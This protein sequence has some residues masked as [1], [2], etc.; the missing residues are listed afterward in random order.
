[1]DGFA[2]I[3][4]PRRRKHYSSIRQNDH[5]SSSVSIFIS[6]V[7]SCITVKNIF[8]RW[9]SINY[10]LFFRLIGPV[11]IGVLIRYQWQKGAT[12]LQKITTPFTVFVLLFNLT[13]NV[14]KLL[15][16]RKKFFSNHQFISQY[17]CI[18]CVGVFFTDLS[19]SVSMLTGHVS[20]WWPGS[21]Y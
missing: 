1:M 16:P 8:S 15:H 12:I 19:R 10:K 5:N 9:R 17:Y 7:P 21:W 18:D 14:S 13:V 3:K 20:Y 11:A 4:N 6:V 2:G